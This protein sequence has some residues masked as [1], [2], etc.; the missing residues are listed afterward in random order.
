MQTRQLPLICRTNASNTLTKLVTPPLTGKCK[1]RLV[2]AWLFLSK[3]RQL[4]KIVQFSVFDAVRKALKTP[5]LA[6]SSDH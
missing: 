5:G 6:S 1:H 3:V 2:L 4:K